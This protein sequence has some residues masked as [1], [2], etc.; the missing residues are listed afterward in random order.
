MDNNINIPR[1]S[2][3]FVDTGY[4]ELKGC[5]K[6]CVKDISFPKF[7]P[8]E[9][10][11]LETCVVKAKEANNFLALKMHSHLQKL[12]LSDPMMRSAFSK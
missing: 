3:N 7:I 2:L 6:K 4:R 11:C 12:V 10:E 1:L 5:F 8:E 9:Q